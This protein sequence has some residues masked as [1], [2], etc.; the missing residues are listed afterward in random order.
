MNV[1]L[2]MGD[3]EIYGDWHREGESTS[4]VGLGLGP[5]IHLLKC[6]QTRASPDSTLYT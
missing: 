2:V 3:N 1:L 6:A 4:H 5:F